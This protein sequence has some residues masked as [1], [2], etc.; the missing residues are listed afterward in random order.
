MEESDRLQSMGSQRVGH[1]SATSLTL[2]ADQKTYMNCFL[3]MG[4]T[5]L[6]SLKIVDFWVDCL[7]NDDIV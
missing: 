1:D 6:R 5:L 2:S 3:S 4:P 7:Y